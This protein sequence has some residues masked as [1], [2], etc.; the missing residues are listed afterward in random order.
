MATAR[1]LN[2][3]VALAL[4]AI[5]PLDCQQAIPQKTPPTPKRGAD[6]SSEV[7]AGETTDQD[8]DTPPKKIADVGIASEPPW[9]AAH[10]AEMKRILDE[11]RTR[12][13]ADWAIAL[14]VDTTTI[15]PCQ[16]LYVTVQVTNATDGRRK[17][18]D[19]FAS[20][21]L[22]MLVGRKGEE[23][24]LVKELAI[25]GDVEG[26]NLFE[27]SRGAEVAGRGSV[28]FD[29]ILTTVRVTGVHSDHSA[30]QRIFG[31]P[32][33]Y[34]IY[35]AVV[36]LPGKVETLRSE[37]L[38]ITVRPPTEAEAPYVE[39]FG[40]GRQIPPH[41]GFSK[42][43]E[44]A[45]DKQV[46]G[47]GQPGRTIAFQRRAD[48][49][50]IEKLRTMLAKHPDPPVADDMRFYFMKVLIRSASLF[51]D[52]GREHGFDREVLGDAARQYLDI[53]P[54]R[55]QLRRRS[56]NTWSKLSTRFDLDHAQPMFQILASW[57]VS[58]P[59]Y[60]DEVESQAALDKIID[61]IESRY[62][63]HARARAAA[64]PPKPKLPTD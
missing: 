26:T 25:E 5:A 42:V 24:H 53:A 49:E 40:E 22:W 14:R 8:I 23:P 30:P 7:R 19:L 35:A 11:R 31:E 33:E 51:D 27:G 57:K 38:A 44:E 64:R 6:A 63:E 29:R 41:Y 37:P 54:Q 62:A 56:I 43:E 17:L 20:S 36:G 34:N 18:D 13:Q 59:F 15:V 3:G 52:Q 46:R 55:K 2:L 50:T 39:F 1:A 48:A 32:G 45:F 9:R 16:P 61:K 4:F 12:A 58:S 60:D 10:R 21:D 28:F 47:K